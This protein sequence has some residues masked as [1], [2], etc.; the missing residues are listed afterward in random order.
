MNTTLALGKTDD[1]LALMLAGRR[2]E[3]RRRELVDYFAFDK[4]ALSAA[5]V[6]KTLNAFSS[7]LP[8]WLDLLNRSF[9]PDDL[10]LGYRKILENRFT[11]LGLS[12]TP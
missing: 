11:R 7:A 12:F 5:A 10:R 9:L 2:K 6:D 1:E 4:L 3:F 8:A